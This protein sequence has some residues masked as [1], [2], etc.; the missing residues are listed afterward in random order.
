MFDSLKAANRLR[1][2]GSI[3]PFYEVYYLKLVDTQRRFSF[4]ARYTVLAPKNPEEA[5]TASLWGIVSDPQ[6][7]VVALKKTYS[8]YEVD[9][10]HQDHFIQ[11]L[12]NHLSVDKTYGVIEEDGKKIEWDL[13]FEDPTEALTLYPHNF[14][15]TLPFPKTKFLEPR[16]STFVSGSITVNEERIAF[17]RLEAHQ[18]HLWGTA[19]AQNWA[20]G[21]CNQFHED[22]SAVFEGLSAVIKLGPFRLKAHLFYFIWKNN[23]YKATG[24]WRWLKNKSTHNL[25]VWQFEAIASG[26]KFVGTIKRNTPDIIGVN[27][28]GPNGEKRFCHSSMMATMELKVF[29]K[30]KKEW[31]LVDTLTSHSAA[32]E[33]VDPVA[34][35]LVSFVL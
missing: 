16:L 18:A 35:P 10:F 26:Y 33:T 32:F 20:W 1:W 11:I 22:A 9:I 25:L 24:M 29:E 17:E 30:Q 12:Q 14:L 28:E 2:D 23:E 27:Y 31:I 3:R 8:L 5:P 4:W 7:G 13:H 6:L 34:D 21:N 19:Y 15:Y